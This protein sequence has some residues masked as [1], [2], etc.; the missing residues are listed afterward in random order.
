M[1]GH[2]ATATELYYEIDAPE[3]FTHEV[4]PIL[5]QLPS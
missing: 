3:V 1:T 4:R 5:H 2:T